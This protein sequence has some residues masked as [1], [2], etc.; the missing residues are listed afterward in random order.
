VVVVASRPGGVLV[1]GRVVAVS[2][3]YRR[4]VLMW[5]WCRGGIVVVWA[6]LCWVGRVLFVPCQ[7]RLL[8]CC[9]VVLGHRPGPSVVVGFLSCWVVCRLSSVSSP[10]RCPGL[11]VVVVLGQVFRR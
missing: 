10:R 3:S 2:L 7:L 9:C 1:V 11:S 6:S 5:L 8:L 4:R